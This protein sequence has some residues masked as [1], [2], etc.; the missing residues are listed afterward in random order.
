[1]TGQRRSHLMLPMGEGLT[2]RPVCSDF[3]LCSYFFGEK[4]FLYSE[5]MKGILGMKI[6]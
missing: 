4:V 3:S 5:Y 2:A 6:L 1:M